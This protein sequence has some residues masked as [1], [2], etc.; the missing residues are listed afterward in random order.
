[1]TTN[2][3]GKEYPIGK[4]FSSEFVFSIPPYQRPYSWTTEHAE[5]LL[6]DL[7]TFMGDDNNAVAELEPYFLGSIVLIKADN[8]PKA[9]VVD[10]QQRLTTLAILLSTL[11]P[12]VKNGLDGSITKALFEEGN[13]AEDTENRPRLTLR[14]RDQEFFNR[15]IQELDGISRLESLIDQKL[16]DAQANIRDNALAISKKLQAYS[17]EIREKLVKFIIQRCY[18]IVVST[19]NFNAAYRIFSILNVRGMDLTSTD[20]LKARIIG[21]IGEP[22]KQDKYTKH[23]EDLEVELGRD[24]FQEVFTHIRMIYLKAKPRENL[25]DGITNLVKPEEKPINFIDNI[26]DPYAHAYDD[27]V[28]AAYESTHEA[29]RLNTLFDWLNRIDNKDWLPPAILF[30][31]RNTGEN[32]SFEKLVKFFTDLER[33]AAGLMICRSNINERM[34]RYGK[35]LAAIENGKDLYE[36]NSP[37]QLTEA[38]KQSVRGQLDGNI[39]HI[40][41]VPR[42]VLLRL[43][44]LLADGSAAYQHNIITIEHVLPQTPKAGSIWL[45]WFPDQTLRDEWT[46]R[47][48]NLVLLS[49]RKNSSAQNYEFDHKKSTYF[50]SND[51]VTSFVLTSQVREE[52][53]WTPTVVQKRQ[54]TLLKL[55]MDIWRLD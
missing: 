30:Y 42:Y 18:L 53:E 3:T 45:N 33:L 51:G 47:L 40:R 31:A 34:E 48:G 25:L 23:W 54:K 13:P 10:G 1:M 20:I 15:Y 32:H 41:N 49:R 44:S 5:I 52:T 11:R 50:V 7:V 24:P 4:V 46:H 26:L 29:I 2:I 16:P 38:E 12:L 27:I 19:P 8:Q 17:Q 39:Y 43:D 28:N 35:L 37:L 21:K 9:D 22:E 36:A 6:D 55:L 14:P